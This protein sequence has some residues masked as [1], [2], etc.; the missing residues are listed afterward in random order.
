MIHRQ[1]D[2]APTSLRPVTITRHFTKQAEGSV[3]IQKSCVQPVPSKKSRHTK[4]AVAKAGSPQNTACCH[5][6][7]TPDLTEKLHVASNL[8]AH[9][10]FNG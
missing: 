8:D 10:K 2:R 6:Q 7:P 1:H 3:L 4:K 5:G 9:R